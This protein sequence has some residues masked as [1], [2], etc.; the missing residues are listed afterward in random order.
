MFHIS[1][2]RSLPRVRLYQQW[3][4]DQFSRWQEQ[5]FAFLMNSETVM[6]AFKK[7]LIR[8]A[9]YENYNNP[10]KVNRFGKIGRPFL[11]PASVTG[12]PAA[13]RLSWRNS[14]AVIV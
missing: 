13:R 11:I 7:R 2:F 4:L 6:S 14:N 3:V 1:G 9:D 5:V 10:S 12:S 8:F